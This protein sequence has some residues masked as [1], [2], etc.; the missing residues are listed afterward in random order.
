MTTALQRGDVDLLQD[1]VLEGHGKHLLGK[2]S[3]HDDVKNFLKELPTYLNTIQSF[4]DAVRKNDLD[5]VRELVSGNE[6]L[7]KAR[8]DMGSLPV[9]IAATKDSTQVLEYFIKNHPNILNS[10]DATGKTVL[11]IAGQ[12]GNQELCKLLKQAGTDPKILDQLTPYSIVFYNN[13]HHSEEWNEI[14]CIITPPRIE[15]RRRKTSITK[16]ARKASKD[17]PVINESSEAIVHAATDNEIDTS[18]RNNEEQLPNHEEND[19]TTN[20]SEITNDEV[21]T[22]E[23]RESL[24]ED[25]TAEKLL[26]ED[27]DSGQTVEEDTDLTEVPTTANETDIPTQEEN[28]EDETT[29]EH[30]DTADSDKEEGDPQEDI[31]DTEK[32][33]EEPVEASQD[34][35]ETVTAEDE[36]ND[37]AEDENDKKTKNNRN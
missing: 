37:D 21:K 11:H 15:T 28:T 6:K 30:E 8:D 16:N 25:E 12:K 36:K 26:P 24:A 17:T 2:T 9:H 3:W 23:S 34:A 31:V 22:A 20:E 33:T 1:L 19:V 32:I 7:L 14:L 35:E 27:Q 13:L 4:H 10:K 5:K 29:K 18:D